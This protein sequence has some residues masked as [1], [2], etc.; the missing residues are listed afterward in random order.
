MSRTFDQSYIGA[1]TDLL[2]R[3][4]YTMAFQPIIKV[5]TGQP[6]GFE[7]LLRGPKGTPLEDPDRFFN[8]KDNETNSFLSHVDM[9]CIWSAV[10]SGAV[11]PDNVKLFIN[12]HGNTVP[13]LSERKSAFFELLNEHNIVPGRIVLEVSERTDHKNV[14]GISQ[15]LYE[16]CET[17]ISVALDDVGIG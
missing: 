2:T 3:G 8:R 10:R 15:M 16:L 9:A 13:Q 14:Q 11:L 5:D 1:V 12:I 4:F 17:G 6:F 7:A